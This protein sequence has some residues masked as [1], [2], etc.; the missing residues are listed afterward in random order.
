MKESHHKKKHLPPPLTTPQVQPDDDRMSRWLLSTEQFG[1]QWEF[2]W[3]AQNL[4]PVR[5]QKIHWRSVPGSSGGS[6]GGAID[7]ANR[8]AIRF[9]RDA[10]APKTAC[11]VKL[12]ISYEVPSAL[13]PVAAAVS[14][15]VERVLAADLARFKE[16]AEREHGGK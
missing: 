4:T 6:L 15:L 7:I 10:A 9:Y 3:L 13:A 5:H 12:T 14:P 2:S 8:G 11:S 16:L 1:R